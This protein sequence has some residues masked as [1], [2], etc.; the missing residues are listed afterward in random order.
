MNPEF[1]RRRVRRNHFRGAA[2]VLALMA[3]TA[4][5][6]HAR[7][8]SAGFGPPAQKAADS[9]AGDQQ[10]P[11][12]N[13][14][15]PQ[16]SPPQ[17]PPAPSNP[18]PAQPNQQAPPPSSQPPAQGQAQPPE[19]NQKP[20]EKPAAPAPAPLQLE[21]PQEAPAA[22]P[23]TKGGPPAPTA[24]TAQPAQQATIEQIKFVG[25]R[26]IP[27]AT[28]RARIFSHDGDVY[29]EDALERDLHALW[30]TGF[31]D[32]IR[33][34][35]A[36]GKTGKIVTFY[37]REKKL[38]RSIDYKGLSTV[39]QSDVLD[40]FREK[41]VGLSILSQYDPVVVKRAEVVLQELLAEHGR[42]FATVRART[43]NIPPNSVA[44]T[45]IVVEGPKVQMGKVDF[46]GNTVF[47]RQRLERSMKYSRPSG[48]PPWFYWFH[49]TYDKDRVEA[50]LEN[51]RSLYQ[52]HGYFVAL[53]QD[54]KVKMVDTHRRFPFFFLG[55][56]GKRVDI[57]IPLEEGPQYR[58]GKFVIRGNKLM[59]QEVLE[60]VLRMKSGDIFDLS[61]VRKALDDYKKLYGEFGYI[62]FVATPDP[63]RDD[64][65]HLINLGLD[66]EEDKQF[67]VHRIE[68]SGNTKTRD[69]VIRRDLLLDEG[70]MFNTVLWDYSVLRINQLGFFEEVKKEDYDIKQNAKD[71]TVDILVKVKEKGRNS[72]G[73]SGGVSG[74]AGTFVG[75]NYATNNF[76]G[77]GE[78][79]SVQ[80]QF[81][82]YQKLY[83]F[84]FTE[85]H[86]FDRNITTGFTV[87]RNDYKFDQLR[88]TLAAAGVNP[89]VIQQSAYTN[90]LY[91]NF[92]QNSDGFTTFLSYP[93]HRTFARLGLTYS[94]SRSS[95]QAF[96]A[97]ST[98][99]FDAIN[100]RG[101][102]GP[103]ALS[104]I[105]SSAVQPTYLYNTVDSQWN[106]H[107][108]KYIYA[109]VSFAGSVLGGNVKTITPSVE[110]K[111]FHP[112]NKGRHVLGF[113]LL[114]STVT[115]Y[116]GE[117]PPPFNRFFI[118]GENDLRGFDFYSVSPV[119]FFPSIGQICNRDNNGNPITGVN[120]G[121]QSTG[122]CGSYTQFPYNTL[123]FPGGD[124][125]IVT[126]SEY[127]VPIIPE[128]LTVSAFVDLGSSFIWHDSQLQ[129]APGALANI[130]AQFPDYQA[131]SRIKPVSATNYRP[132]SSTGLEVAVIMPIVNAPFRL[133]YGY[134]W[135]R[136]DSV[137]TPPGPYPAQSMFP[138]VQTYN[139]ALGL[140]QPLRLRDRKGRLGFTVSRTF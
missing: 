74:L 129:L 114:T 45:F 128:R 70:N 102:A 72:I 98:A 52:D 99:Y 33:I 119:A 20:G 137:L 107:H 58:M 15:P 80:L 103:N 86:L 46:T 17:K 65:R 117:S 115:G 89:S 111:Y 61:K 53:V 78:T 7:A 126:N 38:V 97:A 100:F 88:Q 26:R 109:G 37:V 113:H 19:K 23:P 140:F 79:L 132:R 90:L 83:S 35:S 125:E 101:F 121:G 110:L 32:D 49:K 81:G 2:L 68:F 112:I 91:Q 43:R 34:E 95:I 11:A 82:T 18:P 51:V 56:R 73:F 123:I 40:R 55:G 39:Q 105:I 24:V 77:L 94:F 28:M 133:F 92:Q 21:A 41:K 57:T 87:F 139:A 136:V 96:S 69:K 6:P 85:P 71:S 135:L 4:W 50:D 14:N 44:L 120:A 127:R 27:A 59:K 36:D 16:T 12:T 9:P 48:L 10:P 67:F 124:T 1:C 93:L 134:N 75:L 104:G 64:K 138:N 47:S 60:R 29:D 3:G 122:A 5:R 118:G 54:P 42:Q 8:E 84:G 63:E 62:N 108:G 13:P 25:N 76:L 31:F 106:P 30:N 131:P 22:P 130:T 66:F 116:G